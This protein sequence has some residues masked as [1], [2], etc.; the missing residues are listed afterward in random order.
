VKISINGT[1]YAVESAIAI[2]MMITALA[3]L[4]STPPQSQNLSKVNYKLQIYNALDIANS[5]GDLRKNAINNNADSIKSELQSNIPASL[6]F[7]VAIYNQ[8]SNLT[9]VPTPSENSED[10]ITVSYLVSGSHG[11]YTP[12][13][14]RVFAWGFD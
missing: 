3:F 11:N 10:I 5:I 4:L 9:T 6:S 13:E 7:D 12:R 1:L 2:V 14:V 8:T